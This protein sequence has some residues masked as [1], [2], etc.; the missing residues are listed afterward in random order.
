METLA[1]RGYRFIAPV[2]TGN[3]SFRG[4]DAILLTEAPPTAATRRRPAVWALWSGGI[5]LLL[6]AA[7]LWFLRLR[8]NHPATPLSVS[9]LTGSRGLEVNPCFSPDGN[10]IA[11]SWNGP[12]QDN[13]DI[14]VKLIGGGEPLRLTS[15]AAL[16]FSPVWSPDGRSIAF[17][18]RLS[19]EKLAVMLIPALGGVERKITE[20]P[21]YN[22]TVANPLA[23]NK[24]PRLL[25]WSADGEWLVISEASVLGGGASL[26]AHSMSTGERRKLIQTHSDYGDLNPAFS[27]DGRTLAFSRCNTVD[28]SDIYLLPVSADL[29]P[30]VAPKRI[31]FD[32]RTDQPAWSS[33][34]RGLI[35][36]SNRGGTSG[37]WRVPIDA[38]GPPEPVA[39]AGDGVAM[40]AV[41]QHAHRLAYVRSVSDTNIWQVNVPAPGKP[42]SPPLQVIASAL[43]DEMPQISSDGQ[44]VVFASSRSG[45]REIW[46]AASDGSHPVQM[47]S[48]GRHSGT[49]RWSPDGTKIGFDSNLSGLFQIYVMSAEGGTP[50]VVTSGPSEN[51]IPSWSHD[52]R[53]IYFCSSRTGRLEIWKI[54]PNGENLRQV[55]RNG[56][57]SAFESRDGQWLYY[58]KPDPVVGSIWRMP[59]AG[60][61]EKVLVSVAGG[62]RN[63]AVTGNGIYFLR[64][65]ATAPVVAVYRFHTGK[66]ESVATLGAHLSMGLAVSPDEKRILYSQIDY[67]GNDIMLADHYR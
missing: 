55:T 33:D 48:F 1:R 24:L 35:V 27:P 20:I 11:F 21:G 8:F 60:G 36:A 15:D 3:H 52:G 7:G 19:M 67:E 65:G 2:S 49:P 18:R 64:R 26:V 28:V 10:Q 9:P 30:A 5:L 59:V 58:K 37:L 29:R 14:Y 51:Y 12:R 43:I 40:P 4:S 46:M 13:F 32:N 44:K 17:V 53:W 22:L 50:H 16:D 62:G 34:G 23:P 31:T 45:A 63:F 47:T 42:A 39:F 66:T 41:A 54:S 6:V 57:C 38:S 25:A 61:A 56:G